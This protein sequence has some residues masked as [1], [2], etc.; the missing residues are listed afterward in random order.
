MQTR[1][2]FVRAQPGD[3]RPHNLHAPTN[4]ATGG[5]T[6]AEFLSRGPLAARA[7]RL[8]GLGPV[9]A[10]RLGQAQPALIASFGGDVSSWQQLG[11]PW[12]ASRSLARPSDTL[13]SQSS[14]GWLLA[15]PQGR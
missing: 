5:A 6:P 10:A 13:A 9:G 2:S 3:V 1:T 4:Q 8:L 14:V 7:H 11:A 15:N 12:I